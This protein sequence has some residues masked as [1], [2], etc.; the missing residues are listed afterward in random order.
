ML[1]PSPPKFGCENFVHN[2]GVSQSQSSLIFQRAKSV[3]VD[4]CPFLVGLMTAP[5]KVVLKA[6]DGSYDFFGS[7]QSG[8]E[9]SG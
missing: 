7:S 8:E 5:E 9:I 2:E 4:Q 6:S 3:P 1:E